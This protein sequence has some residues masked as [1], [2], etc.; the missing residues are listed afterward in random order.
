MIYILLRRFYSKAIYRLYKHT[1]VVI[2]E[3]LSNNP[4]EKIILFSYDK[5][6]QG[7]DRVILCLT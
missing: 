2:S 6:L 3:L 5:K 4:N 7:R 1:W